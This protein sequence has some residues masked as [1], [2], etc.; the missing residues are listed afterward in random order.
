MKIRKVLA[1]AFV[2]AAM[3]MVS[4]AACASRNRVE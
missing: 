2:A 4:M 1:E 3:D